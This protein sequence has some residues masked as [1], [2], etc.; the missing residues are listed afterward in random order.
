M[1]F[2]AR[3]FH[4]LLGNVVLV[5]ACAMSPPLGMRVP[6]RNAGDASGEPR[7]R[8][9][10]REAGVRGTL[11]GGSGH[12][13][14]SQGLRSRLGGREDLG[15][16]ASSAMDSLKSRK[17]FIAFVHSPLP[18]NEKVSVPASPH[19]L[20]LSGYLDKL[21]PL[22]RLARALTGSSVTAPGLAAAHRTPGCLLAGFL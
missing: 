18:S 17:Q 1:T 11:W 3:D 14:A 9:G 5:S 2:A 4:C 22:L 8:V 19:S 21:R 15:S 13:A 10:V 16:G 7:V 20:H 6:Y 12:R